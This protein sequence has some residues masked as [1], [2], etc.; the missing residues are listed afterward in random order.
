MKTKLPREIS[1][2]LNRK[3]HAW[4]TAYAEQSKQQL[5]GELER[6]RADGATLADIEK[7]L[8]NRPPPILLNT[9]KTY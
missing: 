4:G 6:M 1:S 9:L 2:L 3:V 8:G 5:L 7:Y